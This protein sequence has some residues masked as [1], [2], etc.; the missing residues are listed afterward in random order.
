[1]HL[2]LR[3]RGKGRRDQEQGLGF[4]AHGI[5][6]CVQ[7][8]GFTVYGYGIRRYRQAGPMRPY[9]DV[10]VPQIQNHGPETQNPA[11]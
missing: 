9:L 10:V 2:G 3:V 8:V 5:G 7:G 11:F 4:R 1:M 6:F